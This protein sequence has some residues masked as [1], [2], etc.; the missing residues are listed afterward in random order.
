MM[1]NGV[2]GRNKPKIIGLTGGIGTGKSAVAECFG[3]MGAE[4]VGTDEIARKVVEPGTI[5]FDALIKVFPEAFLNG[6]LNR[7]FLR[8][9]IF[10]DPQKRAQLEAVTHILILGEVLNRIKNSVMK[11]IVIEAPLLFETGLE[12][13]TN[14]TVC[15]VCE[16]SE[17]IRRICARDNCSQELAEKMIAAQMDNDRKAARCDYVI[18]TFVSRKQLQAV[19][20]NLFATIMKGA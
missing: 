20:A 13:V 12:K 19:S 14:I 10:N 18:D 1:G 11:V 4:I 3:A 2:L 16:L 9:I 17:R 6:V 7:R 15:T 8:E 5:G